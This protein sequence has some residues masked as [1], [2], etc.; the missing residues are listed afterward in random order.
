MPLPLP[1][2]DDI[3]ATSRV[4]ALPMATRFRG[5]DVR[6]ALLFQGPEG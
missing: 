3:L 2:L 6:E 5:V 1:S 4:V